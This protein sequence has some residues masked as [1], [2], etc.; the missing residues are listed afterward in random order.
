M[1]T[2]IALVIGFAI[3]A[4]V[5]VY[6]IW[7]DERLGYSRTTSDLPKSS[8]TPVPFTEPVVVA[9][10]RSV[11]ATPTIKRKPRKA[12]KPTRSVSPT[13]PDASAGYLG[14]YGMGYDSDYDGLPNSVDP[15]PFGTTDSPEYVEQ[16]KNF[17]S[18]PSLPEPA[19]SPEPSNYSS[20][21]D[22]GSSY[23]SYD[24]GSSS[25]YD[26]GSSSSYDSGSS[27]Y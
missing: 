11:I 1:G 26:S 8:T 16:E 4:V 5:I 20:S 12:A 6:A 2:L 19:T 3:V 24:S 18:T 17:E 10:P 25:S 21:Y 22:S 9:E 14:I 13:T 15:V 27:S 23:S 7:R